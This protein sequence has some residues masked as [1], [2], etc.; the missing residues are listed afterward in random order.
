MAGATFTGSVAIGEGT[1]PTAYTLKLNGADVATMN[2]IATLAQDMSGVMDGNFGTPLDGT[3]PGVD[4]S[5]KVYAA[6]NATPTISLNGAAGTVTATTFVGALTGNASTATTATGLSKAG[7]M[8]IET[9]GG[10]NNYDI[11]ITPT[12]T[13]RLYLG[14]A[15]NQTI[16]NGVLGVSGQLQANNGIT[17]SGDIVTTGAGKLTVA[18]TTQ[19]N[20][21][22]AIGH[23]NPDKTSLTLSLNGEEVATKNVATTTADGLMSSTDKSKLDGIAANA[24]SGVTLD[25]NSGLKGAGTTDSKLA[26]DYASA[27]TWT[28]TQSF[29]PTSGAAIDVHGTIVNTK[30]ATPVLINDDA[31]INGALYV[32][33]SIS[34]QGGNPLI[35]EDNLSVTGGAQIT[36]TVTMASD[37]ALGNNTTGGKVKLS[38]KT[39]N[40]AGA[41]NTAIGSYTVINSTG[42]AVISSLT[43]GGSDDDGRIA[44]IV[45]GNEYEITV[46]GKTVAQGTMVALVQAGNR[47]VVMP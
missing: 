40:G 2:D 8:T 27:N 17:S 10:A 44:Y 1:T 3:T 31:A 15:N 36:G 47:W 39:T 29:V 30:D 6:A 25:A 43:T 9:T 22:V 42:E 33:G 5:V 28:A 4:G 23:A 45:N 35:I 19:L 18:G 20:G 34:T 46:L 37:V 21:N 32:T 12:G 13:S 24:I 26:I 38:Y 14:N 11:S 16:V 7:A 41:A